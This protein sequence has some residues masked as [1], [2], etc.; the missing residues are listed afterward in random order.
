M[1]IRITEVVEGELPGATRDES[2]I[3]IVLCSPA[4]LPNQ[5]LLEAV[6]CN[7]H[8]VDER[9]QGLIPEV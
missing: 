6:A 8:V 4:K 2:S 1:S 5:V 9:L 3:G 7:R